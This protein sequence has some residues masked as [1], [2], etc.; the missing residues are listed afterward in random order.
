MKV[1]DLIHTRGDT[2]YLILKLNYLSGE[3]VE[4]NPN[5]KIFF[6]VKS[7]P[8]N[9]DFILQK[10]IGS[11]IE[12]LDNIQSYRV[13]IYASDTSNMPLGIYYYDVAV[14]IEDDEYTVT[15]GKFILEY[16][17]THPENEV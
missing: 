17:V 4:Y 9:T 13:K 14:I 10:K 7:N 3:T 12:Y 6:T 5:A 2:K 8:N 11:G 16:D 15:K 1:V